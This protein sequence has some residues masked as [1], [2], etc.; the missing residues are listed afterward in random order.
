[1]RAMQTMGGNASNASNGGVIEVIGAMGAMG[2][3]R[4]TPPPLFTGIFFNTRA[5]GAP[6]T[7]TS[8]RRWESDRLVGRGW[9]EL[10]SR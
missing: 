10:Q 2:A 1:M 8:H 3:M 6:K 4:V 9:R 5:A 7:R